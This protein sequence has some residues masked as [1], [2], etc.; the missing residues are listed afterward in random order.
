MADKK[1]KLKR[2]EKDLRVALIQAVYHGH[3]GALT[4]AAKALNKHFVKYR[5]LP[6]GK[7]ARWAFLFEDSWEGQ[8]T[9]PQMLDFPVECCCDLS[10]SAKVW[11]KEVSCSWLGN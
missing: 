9:G 2:K 4:S 11:R 10:T 5:G 6:K 1:A 7:K 8:T 3:E